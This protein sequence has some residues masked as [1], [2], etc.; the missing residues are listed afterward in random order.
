MSKMQ[1]FTNLEVGRYYKTI[2]GATVRI[3]QIRQRG[4]YEAMQA[5]WHY[6]IS[7]DAKS[8]AEVGETKTTFDMSTTI[9]W[10]RVK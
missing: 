2:D 9:E 10:T 1:K 3:E 8:L 4:S 7:L 6:N 5:M